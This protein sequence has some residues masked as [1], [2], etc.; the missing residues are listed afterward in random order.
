MKFSLRE[1]SRLGGLKETLS[2][3]LFF[4]F[5]FCKLEVAAL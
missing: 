3:F 1:F 4:I 2:S 5:H